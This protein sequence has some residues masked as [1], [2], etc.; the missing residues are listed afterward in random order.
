MAFPKAQ[1]VIERVRDLLHDPAAIRWKDSELI[2]WLNAGV[3]S[4]TGLNPGAYA[5]TYDIP[6]VAGTRQVLPEEVRRFQGSFA[7][8]AANNSLG[9]AVIPVDPMMLA[10]EIPDWMGATPDKVIEHI[11]YDEAAPREF[12]TY[13]P[14]P[15]GTDQ[16][17]TALCALYPTDVDSQDDELSI[18]REFIEPLVFYVTSRALSKD[19]DNIENSNLADKFYAQYADLIGAENNLRANSGPNKGI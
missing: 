12:H 16:K 4:I 1:E 11:L 14:Q 13:P 2:N 6:L 19:A 18:G 15:A 5:R 7:N 10:A 17:L 3:H 8:K 9:R